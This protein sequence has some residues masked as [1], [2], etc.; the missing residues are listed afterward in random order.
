VPFAV[1]IET[2]GRVEIRKG[3]WVEIVSSGG[4]SYLRWLIQSFKTQ[5][6]SIA[7]FEK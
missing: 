5:G 4:K 1:E 3:T 2:G 6:I 7:D